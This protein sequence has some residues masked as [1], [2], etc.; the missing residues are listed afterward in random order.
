MPRPTTRTENRRKQYNAQDSFRWTTPKVET[1]ARPVDAFEQQVHTKVQEPSD[2]GK[3]RPMAPPNRPGLIAAAN[4]T[5]MRAPVQTP[6]NVVVSGGEGA[7][8]VVQFLGTALPTALNAVEAS[9][10]SK[11]SD[12]AVEYDKLR[13]SGLTHNE[14]LKQ[15]APE[16]IL[17]LAEDVYY[18]TKGAGDKKYVEDIMQRVYDDPANIDLTPEQ[19]Y[20]KGKASYLDLVAGTPDSYRKGL[21]SIGVQMLDKITNAQTDRL[22]VKAKEDHLTSFRSMIVDNYKFIKSEYSG[23]ADAYFRKT[24]DEYQEANKLL[25][26]TRDE[27]TAAA[28]SA[29]GNHVKDNPTDYA[30][31]DDVLGWVKVPDKNGIAAFSNPKVA[32]AYLE[33]ESQHVAALHQI[34]VRRDQEIAKQEKAVYE[35]LEGELMEA[36]ST[37]KTPDSGFMDR[38]KAN[39]KTLGTSKTKHLETAYRELALG[40]RGFENVEAIRKNRLAIAENRWDAILDDKQLDHL[41]QTGQMHFE[42]YLSH[43]SQLADVKDKTF[44]T[45]MTDMK[46]LYPDSAADKAL[47]EQAEMTG[48][49]YVNERVLVASDRLNTLI[50]A[51]KKVNNGLMPHPRR[52]SELVKETQAYVKDFVTTKTTD[53]I[54]RLPKLT[55][56]QKMIEIKKHNPNFGDDQYD[57]ALEAINADLKHRAGALKKAEQP[58]KKQESKPVEPKAPE[59]PQK[60]YADYMRERVGGPPQVTTDTQPIQPA[61]EHPVVTFLKSRFDNWNG[62][63]AL[64]A[65]LSTLKEL[66]Y[67]TEEEQQRRLAEVRQRYAGQPYFNPMEGRQL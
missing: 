18:T 56:E 55:R 2:T 30:T 48:D 52:M 6:F 58:T 43:K 67:G 63:E 36:F 29:L 54:M 4:N 59:V 25:G 51:E 37:G 24:I 7:Q 42:T 10:K 62:S 61:E 17:G 19:I 49:V 26:I 16:T 34:E 31:I 41:Y 21:G 64:E 39:A 50:Q 15:A 9:A 47:K 33:F 57:T 28:V 32:N 27:V 14:A 11:A 35:G 1:T 13:E 3:L 8:A 20:A 5:P 46:K 53:E 65:E 44:A 60:T 38:L 40:E 23:D 12:A 45:A 22:K 66:I